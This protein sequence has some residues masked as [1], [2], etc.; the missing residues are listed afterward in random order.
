MTVREADVTETAAYHHLIATV[1]SGG[2]SDVGLADMRDLGRMLLRRCSAAAAPYPAAL[3]LPP[4]DLGALVAAVFPAAA[5]GWRPGRCFSRHIHRLAG[6]EAECP[7]ACPAHDDN[8]VPDV[9]A[10][11]ILRL[12]REEEDFLG[13]LRRHRGAQ[14]PIGAVF[15]TVI[16][17]ACLENDHLWRS[18]GL[19]GRAGLAGLLHRHFHPLASANTRKLRWK[20]FFYERLFAEGRPTDRATVCA[21]CSH[22]SDCYGDAGTGAGPV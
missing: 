15:A 14:D 6:V 20:R 2:V 7:H 5:V 10:S 3:G 18:L 4:D 21:T 13:L 16:A 17:R 12:R 11:E 8:G 19:A 1:A 22:H 9:T